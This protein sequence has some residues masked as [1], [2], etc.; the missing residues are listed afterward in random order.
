MTSV[1][2]N[3]YIDKLDEIVN[4]Y[5]NTYYRPIKMKPIDANPS[6]YIDFNKENNKEGPIFK[7]GDHVR[8]SPAS[9]YWSPGRPE[10]V[11]LQYP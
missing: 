9:K 3:V 1:S 5:N 2:I 8:I 4:K 11:P 10:D 6:L 7:V